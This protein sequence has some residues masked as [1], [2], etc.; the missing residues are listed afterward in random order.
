MLQ[1]KFFSDSEGEAIRE[2]V[3]DTPRGLIAAFGSMLEAWNEVQ[4]RKFNEELEKAKTQATEEI[5]EKLVDELKDECREQLREELADELRDD[6]EFCEKIGEDY[7]KEK[8]CNDTDYRNWD[9]LVYNLENMK[10][11]FYEIS[12][13]ADDYT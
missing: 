10:E 13:L 2:T 6:Q 3:V 8:V 7:L 1:V 11:A 5:R 9:D 4:V 12:R